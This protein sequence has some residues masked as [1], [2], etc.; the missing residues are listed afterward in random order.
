VFFVPA[1]EASFLSS[2]LGTKASA[3]SPDS[4][5]SIDASKNSQNMPIL[6]AN[7]SVAPIL[8]EKQDKKDNNGDDAEEVNSDADISVSDN[9]LSPE[10][11]HLSTPTDNI[12]GDYSDQISV[13]VIR[14]GDSISQIA[15]MFGVSAQTIL[16]ANNMKKGDKLVEGDVLFILPVS[17]I[18]HTVAKGE[19]ISSIA[20][21][22]KIDP[23]D[24]AQFNG[25]TEDSKLTIGDKI[26]IPG[27]DLMVDEGSDKPSP[28]LGSSEAKDENYYKS[29]PLPDL[30]GYFINPLP[31]GHKTQGLHGPGH[32]GIDIG[33]PIGTPIYA[34]ASGVVSL[35]HPGWSGGYGNM[36]II[37]HPNGTKTL[38]AHM[39][40]IGTYTGANVS[41]GDVIGYVGSTGHSTGPHLHFEVFNAKNPGADWS[42]A[43]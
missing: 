13:Y 33:A 6:Q 40:K 41:Q 3:Q 19:T 30:A 28:N 8:E 14:K 29:H 27:G 42:W 7:V 15:D 20:K 43:K 25:I 22:Y 16:A 21:I 1:V 17:G 26:L 11:N 31:T 34:S 4:L 23:S 36:V 5:D 39:S 38:Y 18:E 37:N 2:I 32:R 35:A 12:D 24:I 10:T 9:A